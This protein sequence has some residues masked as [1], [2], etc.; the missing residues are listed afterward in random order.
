[1]YTASADN[2]VVRKDITTAYQYKNSWIVTAGLDDGD[3][4]LVTQLQSVH[5]GQPV[6]PVAWQPPAAAASG[7]AAASAPA[8]AAA[9]PGAMTSGAAAA[10][11]PET[12]SAASRAQ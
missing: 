9:A 8:M 6:V 5:E 1:M 3:H 12:A 2:K 10:S 11:G 4:V 7:A